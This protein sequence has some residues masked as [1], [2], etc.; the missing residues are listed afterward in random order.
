MYCRHRS[1]RV[2]ELSTFRGRGIAKITQQ[3]N[4]PKV[5]GT[6]RLRAL[7]RLFLSHPLLDEETGINAEFVHALSQ[8]PML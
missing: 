7:A 2:A 3:A 6:L 8:Q 4:D 5:H 1:L